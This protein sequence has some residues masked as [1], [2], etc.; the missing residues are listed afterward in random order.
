[1][2]RLKT[3]S[4]FPSSNSSHFH[5]FLFLLL[6]PFPFL[7]SHFRP[8][9]QLELAPLTIVNETVSWSTAV[10]RCYINYKVRL[11]S[12]AFLRQRLRG[13]EL[14]KGIWTGIFRESDSANWRDQD[15]QTVMI[16]KW[17]SSSPAADAHCL[18][19][20]LSREQISPEPSGGLMRCK[21]RGKT[22]P[23]MAY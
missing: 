9:L 1:M 7:S 4:P 12:N 10:S 18:R 5:H 23:D 17:C 16:A 11:V 13:T 15:N 19:V 21:G 8:T 14:S 2:L 22:L 6:L 20:D 3:S